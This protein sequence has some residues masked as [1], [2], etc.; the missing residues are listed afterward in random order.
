MFVLV[1]LKR[2]LPL[3]VFTIELVLIGLI[4]CTFF[5]CYL[6]LSR[7]RGKL[8]LVELVNKLNEGCIKVDFFLVTS[9]EV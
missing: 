1:K 5:F 6:D 7:Q 4:E 2:G 9:L 3:V 8:L